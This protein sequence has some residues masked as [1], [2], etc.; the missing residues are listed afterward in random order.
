MLRLALF[1]LAVSV[2]RYPNQP[3]DVCRYCEIWELVVPLRIS[4]VVKRFSCLKVDAETDRYL[5]PFYINT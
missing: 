4:V 1:V 2:V 3:R 5:T